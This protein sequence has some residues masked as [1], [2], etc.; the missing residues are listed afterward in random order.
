MQPSTTRETGFRLRVLPVLLTM[1][2]NAVAAPQLDEIVVTSQR[3]ATSH[4][5]HKGNIER[6]GESQVQ[7][8]GHQHI[9]ELLVQVPGAWINRGSGQEHLT[10]LRSPI[11]T[12]A[13]SCG[14]FLMLEDGIPIRPS[15]FCNV[16]QFLEL[17]TEQAS[18]IEVIRGPGSAL[19]GSNALHGIFNV[20]LPE[21]GPD[22]VAN[23]AVEFGSYDYYRARAMLPLGASQQYLLQGI[24]N[25]DIGFRQ[26]SGHQ[27][28]KF[29]IKSKTELF[30]GELLTTLSLSDLEQQTA[31]FIGGED[32]YKDSALRQT[33]E[34]PDAY[35]NASSQR[36]YASWTKALRNNLEIDLRPYLRH[37]SMDFLQH[38]LPGQPVEKNHHWSAGALLTTRWQSGETLWTVGTD[39]EWSRIDLEES[40]LEPTQGSAFLVETRP[41]GKH[42]DYGVESYGIA[43]F[44]NAETQLSDALTI[45]AGIRLELLRHSYENRMLTGNTRDD[46][47]VC[48]FGGC[49][50]SRPADRDDSFF[51]LAPKFGFSYVLNDNWLTFGTLARGFRAPQS[52]ELYR[53]QSGQLIA[54]LDSEWL[55]SIEFGLR[56]RNSGWSAESSL[57]LMR[58]QHSVY[59]DAES[60]NVSDARTRHYGAE[61]SANGQLSTSLS[62]RLN[63]SYAVHE[64]DFNRVASRGETFVSGND[65][66]TAPR[67]Q[68]SST[69]EWQLNTDSHIAL[70]WVYL[71]EY[72]A[73]AE[74]Q[75]SYPGHRVWNLR[76]QFAVSDHLT[77]TLRLKNLANTAYADRAD[78]A[79]GEFRYFP[80]HGRE[81]FVEL[82]W[83][84]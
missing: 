32:A 9:S 30:A 31:G 36:L 33:N 65:V 60:F 23:A 21:P 71:G 10:A 20:L 54:D 80:G 25:K 57:F 62:L 78:Y 55:D 83:Q 76:G 2:V 68:G 50:Y 53:L 43:P 42:Y 45:N 13:G 15:S 35:R 56:F 82:S 1:T 75:F 59:R 72:Y 73:D 3:R 17:N 26:N 37:S 84:E 63:A 52:T 4:W 14:A 51:N 66:D 12:G 47:T 8:E 5:L 16:N 81:A 29:N 19:Y 27:Q 28:A 39:L 79:F 6:L 58:K 49:L 34:N 70:Q 40:Q 44:F 24:V 22:V 11:L 7:Q 41:P 64:Y 77:L 38:F 67:W 46:G 74:N 61:L 69:L 48:G 18:A